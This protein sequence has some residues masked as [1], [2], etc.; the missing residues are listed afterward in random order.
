[1][2]GKE[3]RSRFLARVLGSIPTD[4]RTVA[5]PFVRRVLLAVA[6]GAMSVLATVVPAAAQTATTPPARG[7]APRLVAD[8]SDVTVTLKA[9]RYQWYRA[10]VTLRQWRSSTH[11]HHISYRE[12]HD[13]CSAV[14]ADGRFRGKWQMTVSLWQGHGGLN[15]AKSPDKATCVEQDHVARR[16]W[17]ASWWWPW[18]G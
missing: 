11:G 1:V 12:S 9:K 3:G 6:V 10:K 13:V 15:Y 2:A 14:S 18:G 16:V 7:V 5:A 8:T 17:V 4:V